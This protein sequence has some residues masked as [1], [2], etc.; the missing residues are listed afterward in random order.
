MFLNV[1]GCLR[2]KP[3]PK[4]E[5]KPTAR[6]KVLSTMLFGAFCWNEECKTARR[7]ELSALS[8]VAILPMCICCLHAQPISA[9][10]LTMKGLGT[11]PKAEKH[12]A[13]FELKEDASATEVRNI[14]HGD[15]RRLVSNPRGITS[16]LKQCTYPEVALKVLDLLQEERLDVN[17][18]HFSALIGVCERRGNWELAM[19]ILSQMR[20]STQVADVLCYMPALRA[21]QKRSAWVAAF[22]LFQSMSSCTAAPDAICYNVMIGN[23]KSVGTWNLAVALLAQMF[24]DSLLP[25]SIIAGTVMSACQEANEWSCALQLLT[26]MP[27]L[28]MQPDLI[29]FNI[30]ISCCESPGTWRIA[31]IS[32]QEILSR[33]LQVSSVSFN[34]AITACGKAGQWQAAL[35]LLW[36]MPSS[37]LMPDVISYNAAVAA[38]TQQWQVALQLLWQMLPNDVAPVTDRGL[39]PVRRIF[40]A[41]ST[42]VVTPD[43]ITYNAVVSACEKGGQWLVALSIFK[44]MLDMGPALQPNRVTYQGLL[45]ACERESAWALW[46]PTHILDRGDGVRTLPKNQDWR[47][48]DRTP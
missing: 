25:S 35:K 28:Q 21:C 33:S 3:E 36:Q 31:L 22:H 14:L 45:S 32:L 42:P 26:Q 5:S 6:A 46:V 38:C 40:G 27:Q 44:R 4:A 20:S 24:Q 37:S 16:L 9:D 11:Q 39:K 17:L 2:P 12:G 29:C 10:V 30:A 7:A 41:L 43:I 15:L 47:C 1:M 8:H 34:S 19:G 18:F 13:L 48:N 23:A